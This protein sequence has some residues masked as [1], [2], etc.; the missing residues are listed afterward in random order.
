MYTLY[1]RKNAGSVAV[2]ALLEEAGAPYRMHWVEDV[3]SE[4]FLKLN[5]NG[6]VPALQ[7]P[8][9]QVVYESAAML[10]FLAESLPAARMTPPPGSTERALL[11]QWMVLLSAGTYETALR[12][13]YS[14][15]Y[16][17]PDSVKARAVEELDRLYGVMEAELA[18][19]GPWLCGAG[20]S[21]ADLYLA[22]LAGWYEPAPA[23]LGARFPRILALHD[24]VV[25]RPAW[26]KVQAENAG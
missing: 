2:Q 24:A 15:R 25:A 6:K 7:L 26:Q 10:L 13:F 18:R 21:V 16:G 1:G 8:D 14:D 22:M 19:R 20:I 12:Y 3:K 17:E 5:P 4:S 9:G 23:A 11:L